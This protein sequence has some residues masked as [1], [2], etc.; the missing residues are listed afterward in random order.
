[1]KKSNNFKLK[2]KMDA[3]R[4]GSLVR[5]TRRSGKKT[6]KYKKKNS[7]RFFGLGFRDQFCP[8]FVKLSCHSKVEFGRSSFK[9]FF[10]T[11][12]LTTMFH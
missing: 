11:T 10:Y 7:K 1:M 3:N 5:Q 9:T 6:G 12:K 4:P 2:S 8:D